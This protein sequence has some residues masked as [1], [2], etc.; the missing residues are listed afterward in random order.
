MGVPV[1]AEDAVWLPYAV[2][3]LCL[4]ALVYLLNVSVSNPQKGK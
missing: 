1:I 3:W 2:I 4:G